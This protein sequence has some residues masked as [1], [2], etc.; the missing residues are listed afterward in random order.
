[1]LG[2]CKKITVSK[3][4]TIILD[5]E[6]S[7]DAINERVELLKA[8]IESTTSEYE[9]EK[10]SERLAKMTGGVAIIKVGGAS[11]VEVSEKKDR[12]VD[13][14][15]ATRAAVEEGIVPG[16]GMALL[17]ASEALVSKIK[18]QPSSKDGKSSSLPS[19]QRYVEVENQDQQVGVNIV[20]KALAVPAKSILDNAGIDGSVV[21][22]KLLEEHLKSK[23]G[24]KN[25]RGMN[26]ATGEY[27][28]IVATGIVDPTKVVKTALIDASGVASMMTTTEAMVVDLPPKKEGATSAPPAYD[29]Y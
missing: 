20:K 17:Y 25:T 23:L 22:G 2:R 18:H 12:V 24:V 29:D 10:L 8:N 1:M 15:H 6:G 14:Y 16:G 19:S 9:K 13:A 7:K 26:A 4:D 28:D 21:V 5:G 11:E 27:V 3:D